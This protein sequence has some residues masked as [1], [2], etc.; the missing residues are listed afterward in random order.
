MAIGTPVS[1]GS[2]SSGTAGSSSYSL[3]T[4]A[5]VVA[6]DLVVVVFEYDGNT[7][8]SVS[9]V[10]LGGCTFQQA[11]ASS[12]GTS[13]AALWYAMNCPGVASGSTL[14]V[15]LSTTAGGASPAIGIHAARV[16]GIIGTGALDSGNT[17]HQETTTSTPS[18]ATGTLS[19]SA[20]ALFGFAYNQNV[21][22]TYTEASG[23]STLSSN[24]TN[25][26]GRLSYKVVAANSAVTYAPSWSSSGVARTLIAPFLGTQATSM[27]T[28]AGSY[29]LTGAA[30]TLGKLYRLITTAGAYA[31][32]GSA[33]NF[34]RAVRLVTAAGSYVMTG[35]APTVGRG[36]RMLASAGSYAMTGAAPL[37]RFARRMSTAAGSYT[38]TGINLVTATFP[39]AG[40]LIR[41][42]K[43]VLQNLRRNRPESYL[44]TSAYPSAITLLGGTYDVTISNLMFAPQHDGFVASLQLIQGGTTTVATF[45]ASGVQTLTLPP[46]NYQFITSGIGPTTYTGTIVTN[47]AASPIYGQTPPLSQ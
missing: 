22:V 33:P 3:T 26:Q 4:T 14:T 12:S 17:A 18:V 13:M 29:T 23:F 5:A 24:T 31:L 45:L 37:T 39:S 7:A 41:K 38:L 35:A 8:L 42:S 28:A 10:S 30:A 27:S 34:P 16:T 6:G 43:Y 15:N 2:L 20:E 40:N 32:T 47:Q 11:V 1:I 25:G 36:L 44:V 46:G 19:R 21:A 9:S